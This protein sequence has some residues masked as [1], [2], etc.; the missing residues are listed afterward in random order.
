[1]A[2]CV[3]AIHG[4]P[5]QP[6]IGEF[7]SIDMPPM[8]AESPAENWITARM[9]EAPE[10]HRRRLLRAEAADAPDDSSRIVLLKRMN[11]EAF[12]IFESSKK[13]SAAAK[14]ARFLVFAGTAKAVP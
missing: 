3:F 12:G 13:W 5:P 2:G 6:E 8:V 4:E 9:L 7:G 14:A 10:F 1:M 11:I